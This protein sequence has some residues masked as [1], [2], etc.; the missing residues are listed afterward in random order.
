MGTIRSFL[1]GEKGK[2]KG[3]EERWKKSGGKGGEKKER[4]GEGVPALLLPY[5]KEL[6]T[7]EFLASGPK[8]LFGVLE[9]FLIVS[10]KKIYKIK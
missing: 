7:A 8:G 6:C 1:E 4:R 9:Y 10:P 3:V 5:H 2:R